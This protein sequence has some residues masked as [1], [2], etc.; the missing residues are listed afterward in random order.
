MNFEEMY[1]RITKNPTHVIF[2][3]CLD[4]RMLS[5]S[6]KIGNNYHMPINLEKYDY[7]LYKSYL[8]NIFQDGGKFIIHSNENA[9][10]CANG[11]ITHHHEVDSK[12]YTS[13][14]KGELPRTHEKCRTYNMDL[15]FDTSI[16]DKKY[17]IS[18]D[19][20]MNDYHNH[21]ILGNLSSALNIP[22]KQDEFILMKGY[23]FKQYL[24]LFIDLKMD[25]DEFLIKQDKTKIDRIIIK[26]GVIYKNHENLKSYILCIN[27]AKIEF[28]YDS[29]TVKKFNLMVQV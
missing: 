10:L 25:T 11:L 29:E 20:F 24:E 5:V 15:S 28:E 19:E 9:Y 16:L 7:H 12:I 2:D 26:D 17:E 21:N 18:L 27:N 8:K 14:R 22:R 13:Y 1:D 4:S 6:V 23:Q 3:E